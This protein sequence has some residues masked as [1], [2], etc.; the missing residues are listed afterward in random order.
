ML[1]SGNLQVAIFLRHAQQFL[2]RLVAVLALP[3]AVGPFAEHWRRPGQFAI[4][5]DDLVELRAV[6]EVVVDRRRPLRS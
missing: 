5:G 2:L 1:S 6:E 4:A 3:E